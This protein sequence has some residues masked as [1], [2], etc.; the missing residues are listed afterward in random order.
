MSGHRLEFRGKALAMV[1]STIPKLASLA[2]AL[3][4][5]VMIS[6][7]FMVLFQPKITCGHHGG[8]VQ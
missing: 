5:C 1:L 2:L 8:V 6:M 4:P 7:S 3:A